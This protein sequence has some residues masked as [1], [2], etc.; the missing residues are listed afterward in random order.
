ME[1]TR[2]SL[3]LG[4][5]REHIEQVGIT[6]FGEVKATAMSTQYTYMRTLARAHA[7]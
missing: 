2:L 7:C 5:N 6:L 1:Y 4:S 3:H